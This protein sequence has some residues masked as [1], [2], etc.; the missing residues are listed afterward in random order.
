VIDDELRYI[1][2]NHEATRLL[3]RERD[4]ILAQ[5]F[6]DFSSGETRLRAR[7]LWQRFRKAGGIGYRHVI[8]DSEGI[9]HEV[10]V[11]ARAHCLPGRHL[12]VVRRLDSRTGA[13]PLLTPR[14]RQVLS[15]MASGMTAGQVAG[16]LYLST[17]TVRTHIRNAKRKLA[18]NTIG[19]AI[20]IALGNREIAA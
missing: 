4:A 16:E 7:E 14:E 11:R 9:E 3:G 17:M 12:F 6:G 15:M 18:A 20:A 2:C 8:T 13:K 5:H 19:Q 1:D 10:D